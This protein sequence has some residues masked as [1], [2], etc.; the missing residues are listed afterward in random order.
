MT[1]VKIIITI[2]PDD[3]AALDLIGQKGT[4]SSGYRQDWM[5]CLDKA[6][7]EFIKKYGDEV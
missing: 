7:A 4:V 1:R 5:F 2:S 3:L 6:I